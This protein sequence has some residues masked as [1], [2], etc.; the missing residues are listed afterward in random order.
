[1]SFYDAI[2]RDN[3]TQQVGAHE[4]SH[5]ACERDITKGEANKKLH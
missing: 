2:A 1:M 3:H 5:I 4:L